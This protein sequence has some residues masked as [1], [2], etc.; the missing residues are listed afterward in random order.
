MTIPGLN[1]AGTSIP[2]SD[3]P[4]VLADLD[5]LPLLLRR[6]IERSQSSSFSPTREEQIAFQQAFIARERI[7]DQAGLASWLELH[8]ISEPQMSQRLFQ[9][10]QL[11]QFKLATFS[12][13]IEPL[14]LE[15]KS[16]LDRVTYSLLRVRERAKAV[17]LHLRLQEEEATFAD[18]ASTYSEGI[19]QQFN[20]LI[21]PM[22]LGRINPV[23]AERLRISTS[24]QL[25]PPFEAEG[26][27]VLL[28][29]ERHVPAQLDQAMNERLLSEMYEVWIRDQVSVALA[30]LQ[31]PVAQLPS[32]QPSESPE[33]LVALP[34]RDALE[35][36]PLT[37]AAAPA[38]PRFF[39]SLFA[40]G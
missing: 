34:A 14:F 26:W 18:L 28:R 10:L 4:A 3:L 30:Q 20:G 29:H 23:L 19:E 8:G 31:L 39:K 35:P 5:L 32:D 9:A 17:E 15:R 25:W 36:K 22:E 11:E 7:T 40:R 2:L 37:T 6:H 21:G 12:Q 27:W 16:S 33:S 38:K 1:L 24:G 13:R